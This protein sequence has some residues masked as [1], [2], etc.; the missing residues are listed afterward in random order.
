MAQNIIRVRDNIYTITEN[1]GSNDSAIVTSKGVVMFDTPHK[2]SDALNWRRFVESLGPT[3]YVIVSDHHIDHTLSAYFFGGEMI[4]TV[5][6]RDT[7]LE[8]HPT[9]PFM[10]RVLGHFDPAGVPLIHGDYEYRIPDITVTDRMTLFLGDTEIQLIHKKG[11]TPNNLMAYLPK[12]KVLFSGD[13]VCECGLPSS[14]ECCL[15]EVFDTLDYV[16]ND[17]D[18]DTIVPGHGDVTDKEGAKKYR[19]M[20]LDYVNEINARMLRGDS[21]AK[22]QDE[23]RFPDLIHCDTERYT[24]YPDE[25]VEEFQRNSVS[26]IYDQL[27]AMGGTWD[28]RR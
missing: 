19:Q 11:H 9:I 12:E 22:I 25:M 24:G 18:V 3:R 26:R 8:R 27:L 16:I 17:L 10:D 21:K 7:L 2:A 4:S 15:P 13:N 14:Q 6:T 23:L 5:G 20:Y 28:G 1:L